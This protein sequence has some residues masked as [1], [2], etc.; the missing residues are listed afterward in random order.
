LKEIADGAVTT[1]KIAD[2]AVT[3]CNWERIERRVRVSSVAAT[4]FKSFATL[5]QLGKN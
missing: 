1:A 3:S 4:S 5:L 2:G